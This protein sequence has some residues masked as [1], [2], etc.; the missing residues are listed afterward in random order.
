M[1]KKKREN[2]LDMQVFVLF[3]AE[4]RFPKVGAGGKQSVLWV[5]FCFFDRHNETQ[6]GSQYDM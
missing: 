6:S 5:T 1:E 2:R 4:Q 3:V